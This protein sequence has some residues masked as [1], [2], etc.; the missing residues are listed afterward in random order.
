M[1]PPSAAGVHS[2]TPTVV[3]PMWPTEVERE[4][5]AEIVLPQRARS[6]PPS[7]SGDITR[8]RSD[9]PA[10]G[11]GNDSVKTRISA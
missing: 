5:A 8:R 11:S 7:S 4:H 1:E 2:A 6:A 10:A 3:K 9:T